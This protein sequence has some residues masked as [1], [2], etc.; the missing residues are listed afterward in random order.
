[1]PDELC[2]WHASLDV[3]PGAQRRFVSLLSPDEHARVARLRF[4]RDRR[5]FVAARGILRSILGIASARTP[6]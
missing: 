3:E 6:A 5:R 1:M 4:E 2:V